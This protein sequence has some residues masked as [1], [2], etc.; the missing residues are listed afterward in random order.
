MTGGT[1]VIGAGLLPQLLKRRHDV[2]LLSRHAHDDVR[3]YPRGISPFAAD[4]TD[5]KAL[6]RA[7]DACDVVI[8]IAG[9]VDEEPPKLT[10]EKVNVGGTENMLAEA[11]RAGVRRF[12]YVSSLGADTGRSEYHQSKLRAEELVRASDLS[13]LILRPGNVYGPGDEVI[14]TLLKLVR[15]SPIA[16]IVGWGEQQFQPIWFE[17]LGEAIAE[18]AERADLEH[19]ILE[20]AGTDVTTTRE[21]F[22]TLKSIT[23]RPT[24]AAPIPTALAKAATRLAD[25]FPSLEKALEAGGL[26]MPLTT[27]KLQMLLDRNVIDPPSK[28]ALPKLLERA[29]TSLDEGLGKLATELP[30]LLPDEGVGA[31]ERKRFFIEIDGPS[32]NARQL[33]EDV[34]DNIADVMPIEFQSEPGAPSDVE[35]NA[36]LTGAI[37][38]R[39]HFQVRGIEVNDH[40]FTLA[41]VEG[42]PLAG[43]VSFRAEDI[44]TDRIRF[45]VEVN[46]RA[47]NILDW[48][49]LRT[50]GNRMQ[51]QNWAGVVERVVERSGGTPATDVQTTKERLSDKEAEQ[52]T[53]NIRDLIDA[54]NR[55]AMAAK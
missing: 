14:S 34:R 51:D 29:P 35:E 1:G 23:N 7:A 6:L 26:T 8:H 5:A 22:D 33:I 4:V 17:D 40:E 18:V 25:T 52:T 24:K 36:T 28:N 11:K 50:I 38:G 30:E 21:V 16:P 48:I 43:I 15:T 3:R 54:N 42:H 37:P 27:S 39:G 47:S 31:M 20:L 9:I 41:T 46:A 10:F 49:A 45:T 32:M 53:K 44:P 12:I 13:W 55:E 2:R 19:E